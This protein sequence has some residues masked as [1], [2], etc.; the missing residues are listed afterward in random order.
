MNAALELAIRDWLL[1]DPDLA[2]ITILTGQSA[3]TIPGDQTV[4]FVSC[5]NTDTLALKHYKVRAQLIVSTP[6]VIE[7]SLAAHQG[8]SGSVKSSLLSI[9]GLVAYLPS[10]L[11]L[12]G[13]DL[14]SFSD[15]IGSERFTTTAD[16][17]LAVIEI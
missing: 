2:D 6:A 10:G 12:A 11:I 15:S 14:N 1:A 9:A 7:D 16:L 8:I 17:S 5:E 4:V 3:E 13:A